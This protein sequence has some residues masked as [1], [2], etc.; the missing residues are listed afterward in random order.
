MLLQMPMFYQD[1][2]W[3]SSTMNAINGRKMLEM[4]PLFLSYPQIKWTD[5]GSEHVRESHAVIFIIILL[6]SLRILVLHCS[7]VCM[8]QKVPFLSRLHCF[9]FVFYSF[10]LEM[11]VS[12]E[13]C[14]FYLLWLSLSDIKSCWIITSIKVWHKEQTQKSVNRPLISHHSSCL[15]FLRRREPAAEPATGDL[16]GEER[17]PR[18]PPHRRPGHGTLP[19]VGQRSAQSG[20]H[21]H[22]GAGGRG[23]TLQARPGI[24]RRPPPRRLHFS[25]GGVQLQPCRRH[26]VDGQRQDCDGHVRRIETL[27][28]LHATPSHR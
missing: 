25:M 11:E 13:N 20:G 26:A 4:L 14:F 6:H 28:R 27:E 8:S 23:A 12:Y 24:R 19:P 2:M 15:F 5:S 3:Q 10:F 7:M 1:Y 17:R 16:E 22:G 18:L 21:L 9:H